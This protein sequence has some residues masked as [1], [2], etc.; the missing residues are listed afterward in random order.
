MNDIV[1]ASIGTVTWSCA[2]SPGSSCNAGP[3]NSST[4]NDTVN[5]LVGGQLVYT[6]VG[7]LAAG[8]TG[9][10][11][12]VASVSAPNTV[13]DPIK[14]NNVA[15]DTVT[16]ITQANLSIA[17]S[18]PASVIPGQTAT[19]VITLTNAGP[20]D[21]P[22]ATVS[23]PAPAG[24]T[25][26]DVNG[27]G[28]AT[29]PCNTGT[30]LVGQS[31]SLTVTFAVPSG[32]LTP[33]PFVNTASIT[34]SNHLTP[35]TASATTSVTPNADLA[36]S[37]GS[38]LTAAIPGTQV[39]FTVTVVNN[40]P[41]DAQ[42][43]VVQDPTPAGLVAP[44]TTDPPCAGAVL[45]CNLGTMVMGQS[46]QF[47]VTYTVP[48]DYAGLEVT[49]VAT[50]IA[51][52]PDAIS[53]NNVA[54]SSLPSTP[55]A[56]LSIS[57]FGPATVLAGNELTY[58][59]LITNNGPSDAQGVVVADPGQAN[60]IW[61]Q[62]S[63]DC[64]TSF[65]CNLGTLASGAT[66]SIQV[67]F[68]VP[69]SFP[70]PG[71]VTNIVTATSPTDSTPN[72]ASATTDVQALSNL[73]ITKSGPASV[74]PG[75]TVVYT[76]VVTNTGPSDAQNVIVDDPAPQGLTL[77]SNS[78][79]C[80]VAYP[81][82]FASLPV[83]GTRTIV[84]TYAIPSDYVAIGITNIATATSLFSP[85]P[86]TATVVTPV[87]PQADLEI[88]KSDE[89]DPVVAGT[90]L[91]YTL[92]VTNR[93]PSDAFGVVV[94]DA[95]P[96]GVALISA[97]GAGWNCALANPISCTRSTLASGAV[98]AIQVVVAVDA[99]TTGS[100][101][102]T[103]GVAANTADAI[104][105]NNFDQE[106]T[107]VLVDTRIE[108][109]KNGPA[110]TTPGSVINYFILVTNTGA[111][112]ALNVVV[113]ETVPAFTTFTGSGWSCTPDANAGSV[114]T[115]TI[116][117]LA[118][119]STTQ[120]PFQVTVSNP[121]PVGASQ[122]DNV[123][124]A[125]G[126]NLTPTLP[127]TVTTNLIYVRGLALTKDDGAISTVPGGLVTYTLRYTNTGNIAL[128][129]VELAE[130]VPDHS[131]FVG[132]ASWQGCLPG[133]GAGTHCTLNLGGVPGVGAVGNSGT[134]LFV[135]RV[136]NPL[137]VGVNQLQNFASMTSREEVTADATDTTPIN[138]FVNL[139]LSKSADVASTV[140]GGF[141]NYTLRYTNTGNIEAINVPLSETVPDNTVY[142][143]SGWTCAPNNN[144]GS[145][146]TRTIASIAGGGGN[147]Q[148]SFVVQ[149]NSTVPANTSAI[150]NTA[151]L[152][153]SINATTTTPL[154]VLT[155]IALS[156]DDGGITAVPGA[157]ITY[158]IRYTNTGNAGLTGVALTELIPL[159]TTFAGPGGWSC[160]V[161]SVAGT[162]CSQTI[163][164]VPA[165]TSG[166]VLFAVK[167]NNPLPVGVTQ[168]N[169]T[170]VATS[171][172][173]AGGSAG[174]TTPLTT[175]INLTIGKTDGGITARPNDT[176]VYTLTYSNIGNIAAAN[177]TLTETVP[178]NS[179]FSSAGSSAGWSCANNAPAGSVCT[180]NVGTL[181]GG[182]ASGTLRFAIHINTPV[183]AG[184][185]Q[186]NNVVVIGANGSPDASANDSTPLQTFTDVRVSKTDGD[187]HGT[188]GNVVVYT[189]T[190][191]NVGDIAATGVT[192][193]ETVPANT[194]F[195][196]SASTAGW[197]CADGAVAGT[198]CTMN[199][200]TLNGG[201]ASGALQFAVR[202]ATV[203]PAGVTQ[204]L[205]GAFIGSNEGPGTAGSD[206]T[207]IDA[208]ANIAITKSDGN[209]TALPG[210]IVIYT[211]IARNSGNQGAAGVV[212]TDTV[213]A[214]TTF[215]AA[216]SSAGWSCADGA[217]PGTLCALNIGPLAG[218]GATAARLFAVRLANPMPAGVTSI[219]NTALVAEVG[220]PPRPP[221]TEITP[222]DVHANLR[223]S[224]TV[225]SNS[226]TVGGRL[227][228]TIQAV[229]DGPG[230]LINAV[231]SDNLTSGLLFQSL[232]APAG[233][234]C[235]TPAIGAS[236]VVRCVNAQFVPGNASFTLVAQTGAS[237][238]NGTT[239]PNVALLAG[240]TPGITQ[241][242][243]SPP[244][245]VVI[246][247]PLLV[248]RKGSVPTNG[249]R[250]RQNDLITYT[251]TVTNLGT[252][253]ATNVRLADAIPTGTRYVPGSA[254]PAVAGGPS[255]LR[256]N[257]GDL[258]P[259]GSR[260]VQ[261]TVQVT[262]TNESPGT[263]AI[264]NIGSGVSDQTPLTTSNQIVHVF[265]RTAIHLLEFVAKRRSNSV[266]VQWTTDLEI[267][268]FGFHLYRSSDGR[269]ESATR[270]TLELIPA[271][272]RNGGASY[273]FVDTS[274]LI[275]TAYS[276][277][278]QEVELDGDLIDYGPIQ[279]PSGGAVKIMLP[280]VT[281]N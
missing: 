89:P 61:Q 34:S 115:R 16:I 240:F 99:G 48:A 172:E 170:V 280:L 248:V 78:G 156:K 220:Q 145:A 231:V 68:L 60:L 209:V 270:I 94:T 243:S 215:V 18:G 178:A 1:P 14:S 71:P 119:G 12:N 2:A 157:L 136:D 279:L 128:S 24:L 125:G 86:V 43:V 139:Q 35:E 143:G 101:V 150:T 120:L 134:V 163:G 118:G 22:N 67:R 8:A 253:L 206:T 191:I 224:K 169:N 202:L 212:M 193:S 123:V 241:V 107:S 155:G 100:L 234:T 83:G 142:V 176:V 161:G 216:N 26:I 260:S 214:N 167:V 144:A 49:N 236:G 198:N 237:L 230:I 75:T 27:A 185:T 110:T 165:Q 4:I 258:N 263:T 66:R 200:G 205:N 268:T 222:V 137:P 140:P 275:G 177:V 36:I 69:S 117:M 244:V 112:N 108:I 238:A 20:S 190:Y 226:V 126:P 210:G 63:G 152:N 116:A 90:T 174:D 64:N 188:P 5:I 239:L 62:T 39:S 269:R 95:L 218:G 281:R 249:G 255:P 271:R 186:V 91:T 30:L 19:Y 31:R 219:T 259:G 274:A 227:T 37:K 183:P 33:N 147:G 203:I 131:T 192:V 111:S 181:T 196:A 135:V 158:T 160:P 162:A 32:Y 223:I 265:D 133:A 151:V 40:G 247:A 17:K 25:L 80:V 153:G 175:N 173:A 228:Y 65:P 77:V 113:T 52:T 211:L 127:Y 217:G 229:N 267:D 81:C 124:L 168:V 242:V 13:L 273:E 194:A 54:T 55:I 166:A 132:P 154:I 42:N 148:V 276:F 88:S 103:T 105:A 56:D 58:T 197:S 232:N 138:T 51:S 246:E 73:T 146:C 98:S 179:A 9:Q 171:N 264:V 41:S 262:E 114:C 92:T 256:W 104:P 187:V 141:I 195:V 130:T 207:L 277:W 21:A 201:G 266:L 251:L 74:I 79:D 129:N 84:S 235:T 204:I 82:N 7:T 102:N 46:K 164:A 47:I 15:T 252:A 189:L 38:Q 57:K 10:L 208:A 233:W 87:T 28:C 199:V 6:V 159:N 182:G 29:V 97:S 149:V 106:D 72:S 109:S 23:D 225:S 53:S 184:V 3:V 121:L 76:I 93:G 254:V 221:A 70:A 122:F 11:Q 257:L 59:I 96:A 45:P 213:P 250:V 44:L 261:F 278:L 245:I 272:G 180:F 50:V 85:E